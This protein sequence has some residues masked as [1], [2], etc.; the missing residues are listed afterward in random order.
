MP[1]DPVRDIH[2]K[3]SARRGKWM[4]KERERESSPASDLRL[5]ASCPPPAFERLVSRMCASV[6]RYERE[7]RPYRLWRGDRLQ[8][9]ALGAGRRTEA[10]TFL[11]LV[12]PDGADPGAA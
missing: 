8:V 10:L 9:D 6:L 11:A 4:V 2:W 12:R 7:G 3:A 1:A 5:P